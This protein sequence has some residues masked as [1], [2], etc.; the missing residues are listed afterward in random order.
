MSSFFRQFLPLDVSITS[1]EGS[2]NNP[3]TLPALELI[4][5]YLSAELYM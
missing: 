2:L 5:K 3:G 1:G 4:F